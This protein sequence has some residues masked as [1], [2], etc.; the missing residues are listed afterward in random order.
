V[1]EWS[2]A[3]VLKTA[4]GESPPGVR[5][6]PH[7]LQPVASG[8]WLVAS[9]RAAGKSSPLPHAGEG[10][11][12]RA[13]YHTSSQTFARCQ[14]AKDSCAPSCV[15]GLFGKMAREG[16]ESQRGGYDIPRTDNEPSTD[17][18]SRHR[19]DLYRL[20]PIFSEKEPSSRSWVSCYWFPFSAGR[21][22]A[23]SLGRSPVGLRDFND[24]VAGVVAG[25]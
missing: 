25:P 10:P 11:G 7:P 18:P 24:K 15:S 21:P 12:V 23:S 17:T 3:A 9:G 22:F 5:I 2:K 1:A 13:A 16:Q 20:W 19:R 4:V 8:Q 6:P 14:H